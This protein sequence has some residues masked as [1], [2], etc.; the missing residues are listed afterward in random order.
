MAKKMRR[1]FALAIEVE[2]GVSVTGHVR[3]GD[4]GELAQTFGVAAVGFPAVVLSRKGVRLLITG[5]EELLK[6]SDECVAEENA[7]RA[8]E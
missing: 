5:L 8:R 1:H 6:S 4:S 2:G 3:E 7:K